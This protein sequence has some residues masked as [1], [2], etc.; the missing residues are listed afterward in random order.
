MSILRKSNKKTSSRKQIDIE[1][2]W[3]GILM[4]PGK[5]YRIALQVS[6]VNFELKSEDEQ[7]ALIET[8]QSFL[9]SLSYP[10]QILVRIRELDLDKYLEEF[11]ESVAD[12]KEEIYKTQVQNY[13]EFVEGLVVTNKI[14]ARNFYV[15]IP[16]TGS[17]TNFDIVKEQLSIYSDMV[18]KGLARLGIHCHKLTSLELLDLFYSFYSP[19]QSKRQPLSKQTLNLLNRSYL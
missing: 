3:D 13:S 10:M 19:E 17:D 6:S 9:N 2:V 5:Q 16:F 12:E 4:L 1:G 11:K 14:L 8:Y 7:D 18:A 15:V